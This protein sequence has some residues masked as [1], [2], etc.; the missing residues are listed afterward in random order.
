MPPHHSH[1]E[2]LL[3]RCSKMFLS[4]LILM[5]PVIAQAGK[6]KVDNRLA[7]LPQVAPAP[8]DNPTTPAKV[9]LGKQLFF[10][11][12]LSGNNTMS[13]SSC[14]MPDR[15]FGDGVDWNKGENGITLVRNTPTCMNVGFY[16]SL[17]WDGRAASLEEQAL[18]P[19]QSEI[20]MNQNLDELEEELNEVPSYVEQFH[21]VFGSKPNRKDVAK[22]LATYQRTLVTTPSPFDR[23]L[24]G[25]ESAL[26]ADAKR[27]LEL[28][29]GEARC[30]E[31]HNGPMLSNGKFYRMGIS[32]EDIGREA[33]TGRN[34][35]RYRFR[36]PSLRNVADTGPYMHNG[37]AHSLEAVVSRYYHGVSPTTTDGLE[38]DAPD[39]QSRDLSDIPY[40]LA[41]LESLS[42]GKPDFTPPT[43]PSDR[44]EEATI[45]NQWRGPS[46]DGLVAGTNW[47]RSLSE[48][49]L[50]RLWR[51]ELPPSYSGPIVS[52]SAVFVTGTA[53]MKNEVVLA[54]DRQ[55]GK[56]L[57]RTEWPGAMLVPFFAWSNGSW[58]RSTPCFDGERLFVGGMRD[59][60]VSLD[61]KT[62]KEQWRVDFVKDFGSPLPA[63]G[64]V[65]SPL[66]DGDALY[67]QAGASFVK[68]DKKT[69]KVI[70][71]VLKDE[72]GMMGSAF[73]SPVIATL[74]GQRQL[75]VLTREK[76]VGV[77]L[78]NGDVLW[79][80]K[81]PNFRGM[82]ILT[83]VV[84]GD[85]IFT[86]AYQ[87]KSWF[88]NVSKSNGKFEV[89]EAWNEKAQGY[90]STPVVI[91][92]HAYIHLQNERFA[93]INLT[94][95][96]RTW[97]SKP[98]GKYSSLVAQKD[99]ILALDE[100]GSLLL[101]KAN[102]KEFELL[103]ERKVS[104]EETWAHVAVAGE[105]IFVRELNALSVFRWH[106]AEAKSDQ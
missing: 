33:A 70:W 44:P 17:F 103:D 40:L 79:E 68:L 11:P 92:G 37:L 83:P 18:G 21:A 97:T 22:A 9:A 87:N 96:E 43:L 26:S 14:H 4:L 56:E 74:A 95:G 89:K 55:T 91:D 36:T 5:C 31:C 62:G 25:D 52:E 1:D 69:G 53:D 28:F 8:A 75:V 7:P 30:V 100:T 101:I 106:D 34:E 32:E 19:I 20:E 63:F 42:G 27:G 58:I 102:P 45:W 51:V 65:S 84:F 71:R 104:E 77:D 99:L 35:D 80:Q 78:Q 90:M 93:C 54:L 2:T 29:V 50:Q 39:L 73:S 59:V 13:C 72:G 24:M 23:Y 76:L 60:L 64:F 16:N 88:F 57:W 105:E 61:A 41:F 82:N 47:P 12:R 81:V 15:F 86:S 94:T 98:Y 85:G 10:D 67:V 6:P 48:K 46:R 49:D 38:V 66:L 3:M